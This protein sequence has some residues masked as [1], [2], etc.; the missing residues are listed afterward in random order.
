[1][2]IR[3]SATAGATSGSVVAWRTAVKCGTANET[4]RGLR[5]KVYV[6]VQGV[7]DIRC[8]TAEETTRVGDLLAE[9]ADPGASA[10]L[11]EADEPLDPATSLAA[12]GVADRAHVHVSRCR[13]VEV[14]VRF[15]GDIETREFPPGATV[16]AVFAWAVGPHGFKLTDAERAKHTLGVC[17]G[18]TEADR[19]AHVGSLANDCKLCFD[20]APK[21]RYA[22]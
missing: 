21:V 19:D 3:R 18:E 9:H 15:G 22:G 17:G 10:W 11:E 8:V 20:L 2:E 12:A 4:L 5:M 6:H 1:M 13:R 16:N 14:G 7:E